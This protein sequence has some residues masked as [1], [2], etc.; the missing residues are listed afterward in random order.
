MAYNVKFLKGLA[1]AYTALA[2]KDVNTFY[3]TTDD[4]N[5]YLGS[6]K[7]SNATDLTAALARIAANEKNIGDLTTL[8]TT[9][10]TDLVNAINELK[11]EV[12]ALTGGESGGISDMIEAITGKLADLETTDQ[13][14][15][16]AAINELN[17]KIEAQE[18]SLEVAA[19]PT[20]GY[21]KTYVFKKGTAEMG[22]I[23]I[24]KDL[25]VS[26]GTIVEDPAGQPAGTY[27]ELTLNDAS[28]SKIYINVEDLVDAYTAA[29]GATQVQLAISATNEIS[30]SIVAG[31]IT[32]TELAA[33][34]VETT[35]IK[36]G[37][38]NAIKIATDAIETDKIKDKNVTKA[39]LA[40]DVQDSLDAAD[41][42]IQSVAE[43]TTNGTI[44]VDGTD[45][46]VHGL[47]S[48]AYAETS[49]FDAAGSAAAAE[50]NAKAY[51]DTA[52]TWGTIA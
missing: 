31:S 7:L 32:A 49:A 16:V 41:S 18:V 48:A 26:S 43:G 8:T 4:G 44:A 46:A 17:D 11:A 2:T 45:V 6:I 24:P 40:Q 23:D 28:A 47:K 27:I 5:L 10:K 1:S 25:V 30:A 52:L 42:A 19:T 12:A 39:K 13:S 37:A 38:V 20:S 9:K 34:A 36:D 15:L 50:T 35:K 33:N 3:Y 51:T 29:A 21:A 14:N 22:K